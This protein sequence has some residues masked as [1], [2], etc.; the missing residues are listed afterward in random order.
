M[1]YHSETDNRPSS[2]P[3]LKVVEEGSNGDMVI[4]GL[5]R[6]GHLDNWNDKGMCTVNTNLL[7]TLTCSSNYCNIPQL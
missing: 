4:V 6:G 7:L 2:G 5:H 3:I 1:V